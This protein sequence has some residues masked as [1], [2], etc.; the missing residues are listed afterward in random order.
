M[1]GFFTYGEYGRDDKTDNQE[2]SFEVPVV[3]LLLK[4]NNLISYS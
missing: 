3:G 2:Y 4:K 1:A